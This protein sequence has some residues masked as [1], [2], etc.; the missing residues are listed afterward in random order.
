MVPEAAVG[1]YHATIFINDK[2]R[3][4]A[5]WRPERE[6]PGPAR[7]TDWRALLY[8]RITRGNR[9]HIFAASGLI[10]NVG[11]VVPLADATPPPV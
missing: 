5:D 7:L 8:R 10:V 4:P 2:I 3:R 6:M 9:A 1:K 11:H